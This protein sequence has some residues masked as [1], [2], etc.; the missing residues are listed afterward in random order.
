MVEQ[1]GE[2]PTVHPVA[3]PDSGSPEPARLER[4]ARQLIGWMREEDALRALCGNRADREPTEEQRE[5]VRKAHQAVGH[6]AEGVGQSGLVRPR[7]PDLD[8]HIVALRGNPAAAEHLAAGWDVAM[9]DLTRVCSFQPAVFHEQAADRV[10]DVPKN[11]P[12]ALAELTLPPAWEAELPAQ[13]DQGQKAW[14]LSSPNPNL[15]VVGHFAGPMGD[16]TRPPIPGFGWLVTVTPSFLMVARYQGR[17][18]LKDGYHRAL[19]LLS[20]EITTVPAF[21]RDI[22]VYEELGVPAGMLPQ[23]AFLGPRPPTI[24]DF[25]DDAVSAEVRL[26]AVQKMIVVHALEFTPVG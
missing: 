15:R 23:D 9:V 7:P 25:W 21:V 19:G 1:S 22:A 11:D 6:R 13:L 26:P 4:P 8:A 18:Y 16:G 12:V 10:G 5:V 3:Q 24:P 14:I 17:Y 2:E 20:R